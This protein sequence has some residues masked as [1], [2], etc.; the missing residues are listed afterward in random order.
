MEAD[1]CSTQW[2]AHPSYN[3][4]RG[5]RFASSSAQRSEPSLLCSTTQVVNM[6]AKTSRHRGCH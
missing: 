6:L 2:P 3:L 5:S 1:I 4:L